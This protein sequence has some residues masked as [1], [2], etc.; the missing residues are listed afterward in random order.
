MNSIFLLSFTEAKERKRVLNI[1]M[2]IWI[3]INLNRKSIE[4]I[5]KSLCEKYFSFF[6]LDPV[7]SNKTQIEKKKDMTFEL[8][9]FFV[10]ANLSTFF[11][12]QESIIN[13]MFVLC[14]R[15]FLHYLSIFF[16]I[17]IRLTNGHW[18]PKIVI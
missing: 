10:V 9:L 2:G 7:F 13:K 5:N 14:F 16:H 15:F 18:P 8:N 6:F 12:F 1:F 17:I 3:F 11:S 4:S